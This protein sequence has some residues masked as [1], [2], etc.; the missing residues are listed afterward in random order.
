[1][2]FTVGSQLNATKELKKVQSGQYDLV[3]FMVA[4][5]LNTGSFMDHQLQNLL[6]LLLVG[7]NHWKNISW[8]KIVK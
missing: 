3:R 7:Q 1:M 6:V 4:G 2:E 8:Q 5:T